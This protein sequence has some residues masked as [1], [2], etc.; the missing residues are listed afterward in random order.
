MIC[1]RLFE[2][3]QTIPSANNDCYAS[4]REGGRFISAGKEPLPVWIEAS[5]SADATA[6]YAGLA[7]DLAAITSTS[8][9]N[10]GRVKPETI[11]S[12]EAGGGSVA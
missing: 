12:V 8:T 9:L 2:A 10:S 3:A 6:P 5:V 4:G 11:I 1:L 7:S